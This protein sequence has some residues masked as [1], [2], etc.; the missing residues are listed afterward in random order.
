LIGLYALAGRDAPGVRRNGEV[1]ASTMRTNPC[2]SADAWSHEEVAFGRI[3]P[4][5]A[6][7]VWCS[8]DGRSSAWLD[9]FAYRTGSAGYSDVPA[10]AED[11]AGAIFSRGPGAAL[12]FHGEFFGILHDGPRQRLYAISDRFGTRTAYWHSGSGQLAI[13]SELGALVRLGVAPCRLDWPHVACLLRLNKCRL[14]DA[15]LFASI[16][17]IM[18]GTVQVYDLE[19][20]G[21]APVEHKYYEHTF[22]DVP[23]SEDEWVEE[24]VPLLRRAALSAQRRSKSLALSLSGGLDSRTLLAAF[25]EPQRSTI[26][27]ISCGLPDSADVQLAAQVAAGV[28]CHYQNID[29]GPGDFLACA[30]ASVT[31]LEEFDI[32]VQGAQARLHREAAQVAGGLM[33]GWDL[34]IPLRGVYL[35]ERILA[36]IDAGQVRDAVD[37]N[38][39]LFSAPEIRQIGQEGFLRAAGDVPETRLEGILAQLHEP[40]A[41]R[42]YLRF[43][44]TYEK[45][46]LLMLRSRMA[47]FELESITP[48]YDTTLQVVLAGIPESLKSGNRLFARVLN[49]LS[50]ELA[51][52]PYQRTMIPANV[53][54]EFWPRAADLENRREELLRD[55]YIATGQCLPYR[56][57]YSNF[58]EWLSSD[59]GW[60][61]FIHQLLCSS[62]T[63]ITQDI[64]KP[65]AVTELIREH[66]SRS[67]RAKLINLMSL[68]LYLR[69]YFNPDS[70][71]E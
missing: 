42:M 63:L 36:L 57:F 13:C 65:A 5:R 69:E 12:D 40:D 20:L 46:R 6:G 7:A 9:G 16:R 53:P 61:H 38:W 11:L 31:R 1:L 55:V 47:R 66:R 54:V 22:S 27:A 19:R 24:I 15:T 25:D 67:N 37:E 39:R 10:R 58:D 62:D 49:R 26:F 70:S 2:W 64:L 41:V 4:S 59:A 50:P 35:N 68:E 14:G 23:L 17:V 44:F 34:D 30:R 52:I 29:L 28:G 56:R 71:R 43:L 32:F 45:F 3:G 51:A 21:S 48:F 60:Q 8:P 33:T 18:P